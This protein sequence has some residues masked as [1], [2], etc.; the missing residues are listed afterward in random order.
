MTTSTDKKL[1][2]QIS[3]GVSEF[4]KKIKKED[5]LPDVITLLQKENDSKKA[6]VYAPKDLNIAEKKQ[7]SIMLGKLTG[8]KIENYV[9]QKDE[10]LIDGLKIFYKDKLWDFSV[11][12]QIKTFR[13]ASGSDGNTN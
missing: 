10:K 9:F 4:L 13:K 5:L 11:A 2:I 3:G 12:N 1:A 8:E 6:F 7:I